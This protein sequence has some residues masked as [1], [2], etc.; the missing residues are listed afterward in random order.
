MRI[1]K[2]PGEIF[3]DDYMIDLDLKKTDAA[4]TLGIP[5]KELSDFLLQKKPVDAE[6]AYRLS[7]TTKTSAK[8]WMDI[9][10]SYD[11]WKNRHLENLKLKPFKK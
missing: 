3:Y 7:L 1:P 10:I 9:Q 2:H 11:L 6:L 4:Q 5:E 8:Y